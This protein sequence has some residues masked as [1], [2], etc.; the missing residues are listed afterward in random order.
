L[1]MEYVKDQFA[2]QLLDGKIQDD[3]LRIINDLIYY[4]G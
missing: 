3:N 2:C 1:V 4:K